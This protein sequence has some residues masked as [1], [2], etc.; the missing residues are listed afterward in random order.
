MKILDLKAYLVY[1]NS[2]ASGATCSDITLSVITTKEPEYHSPGFLDLLS[3][4]INLRELRRS[5]R[6]DLP[7]MRLA[8]RLDSY[9]WVAR[10]WPMLKVTEFLQPEYQ[11]EFVYTLPPHIT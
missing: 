6:V 3:G 9:R 4:L 2:A 8:M 10:H 5:V 1:L 11:S 7:V